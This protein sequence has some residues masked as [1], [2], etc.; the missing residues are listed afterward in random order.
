MR[1][2]WIVLAAFLLAGCE[3][4]SME[5]QNRYDVYEPSQLWKNGSE[6][7]PLP[8]GTVSQNDLAL[9]HARASPPQLT[10]AVL[11]T[12]Q[13]QFDIFC[14]PCHARSGDGQGMVVAH[15][16]PAPL[17]LDN[18]RLRS[19][20]AQHLF[21]VVSDGYGVM[22]PFASRIAPADRWAIVAYIRALQLSRHAKLA[23]N[24]AA[25]EKL[26]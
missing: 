22:Y 21:D 12:G 3:P 16:F 4:Q 26:P 1:S 25:R 8:D 9:A 17:P 18:D 23:D 11:K 15:G 6:A 20:S 5:Q 13:Q 10:A 7:Q 19:A 24:P 14:A 2:A